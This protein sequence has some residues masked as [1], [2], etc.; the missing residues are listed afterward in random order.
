VRH[1]QAEPTLDIADGIAWGCGLWTSWDVSNGKTGTDLHW[2]SPSGNESNGMG[3]NSPYHVQQSLYLDALGL[4]SLWALGLQ[5]LKMDQLNCWVGA[6]LG[7]AG[8]EGLA[9]GCLP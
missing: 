9:F 8:W 4:Q 3:D 1:T 5:L 2:R 7:M 6:G